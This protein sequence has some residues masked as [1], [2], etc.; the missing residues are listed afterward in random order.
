MLGLG[1]IGKGKTALQ[2]Q[3]ALL[4]ELEQ[5]LPIYSLSVEVL[6]TAKHW[7]DL[8]IIYPTQNALKSTCVREGLMFQFPYC[9]ALRKKSD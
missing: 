2:G 1:H 7:P 8:N 4:P 3:R 9:E 5:V 6:P